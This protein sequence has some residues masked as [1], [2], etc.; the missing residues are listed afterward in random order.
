MTYIPIWNR[1][2]NKFIRYEYKSFILPPNAYGITKSGIGTMAVF[3]DKNGK[4]Q[5]IEAFIKWN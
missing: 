4:E 3:K 5:L 1:P 2:P